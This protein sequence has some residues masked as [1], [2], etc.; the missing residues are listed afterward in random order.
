M[1]DEDFNELDQ[2]DIDEMLAD[3]ERHDAAILN[4]ALQSLALVGDIE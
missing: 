2:L 4:L 1:D 3:E